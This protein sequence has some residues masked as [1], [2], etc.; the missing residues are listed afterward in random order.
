[1]FMKT[2]NKFNVLKNDYDQKVTFLSFRFCKYLSKTIT[3]PNFKAFFSRR[4]LLIPTMIFWFACLLL[5]N[6]VPVKWQ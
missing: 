4:G 1:M 5:L 2:V 3:M 6:S